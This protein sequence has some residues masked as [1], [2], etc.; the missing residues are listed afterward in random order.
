[1][2]SLSESEVVALIWRITLY[3]VC[4]ELQSKIKNIDVTKIWF[5]PKSFESVWY[6]VGYTYCLRDPTGTENHDSRHLSFLA[7]SDRSDKIQS[8]IPQEIWG[9]RWY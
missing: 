4:T 1:M 3:C 9:E 7:T 2:I 8:I 5:S 6:Q